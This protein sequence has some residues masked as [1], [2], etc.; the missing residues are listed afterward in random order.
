MGQTKSQTLPLLPLGG[1]AVLLPGTTLRVPING[2]S[3]IPALVT[4]SYTR[5]RSPKP[6][7]SSILIGC[8]PL[9]SSLLSVDGQNLITSNDE[10]AEADLGPRGVDPD[11][12]GKKDLFM[13]GTLAKIAGVQGRRTNDLAFVLEGTR[14]FKINRITQKRPFFEANVT[15]LDEDGMPRGFF[16]MADANYAT[17]C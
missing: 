15:L 16:Y 10:D 17:S 2:R 6:D 5:S 3:D 8:V 1:N 11:Q 9:N 13:Y 12:A 7:A 14:R 4:S